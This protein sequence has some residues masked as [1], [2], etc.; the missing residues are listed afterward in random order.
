MS[1]ILIGGVLPILP[2]SSGC[3]PSP[4]PPTAPRVMP[5]PELRAAASAAFA[6]SGAI[7]IMPLVKR[8][9]RRFMGNWGVESQHLRVQRQVRRRGTVVSARGY[10]ATLNPQLSSLN[11]QPSLRVRAKTDAV[12]HL[13]LEPHG[14]RIDPRDQLVAL[15]NLPRLQ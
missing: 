9:R 13:T 2:P 5:S 15:D 8:K 14:G 11:S 6:Q 10:T 12:V 3:R 1:V 7:A 4:R